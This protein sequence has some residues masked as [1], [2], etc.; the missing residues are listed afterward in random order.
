MG[1][2]LSIQGLTKSF[3]RQRVLDGVSFDVGRGESVLL[4][5]P[6]GAG[7]TTIL[8][9][10]L[11]LLKF[12]GEV[13]VDG[14]SIRGKGNEA[15]AE[16]G[17]LPQLSSYY[18]TLT[19]AQHASLM[20]SLKG[21]DRS[22]VDGALRTADLLGHKD[23]MV[24]ALSSGM[25][26]RLGL[27]IALLGGPPL[28][29]LDEPTSNIDME[30]QL[31]FK[32]MLQMLRDQ[33]KSFLL[34]TH[35]SGLDAFADKAVVLGGGRVLAQGTESEIQGKLGM[36]DKVHMKV[37]ESAVPLVEEVAAGFGQKAGFRDGWLS[38]SLRGADKA[39]F[40]DA[41]S[42]KGVEIKDLVIERFSIESEYVKLVEGKGS[43]R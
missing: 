10:I 39:A 38:V 22:E 14:K 19:V 28:L 9:C 41:V 30:G 42:K 8:K 36:T 5:G 43:G 4:I 27:S 40:V 21:V 26:Q 33:G 11:G 35:V 29:I 24:R 16:I 3:G 20:A 6:N 17:Y 2:I 25:R 13:L 32:R 15:R 23:K 34:S 1:P 31:G 7:K 18:E 12:R 37:D